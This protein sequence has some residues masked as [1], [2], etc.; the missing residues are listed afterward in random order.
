MESE[1]PL[2]RLSTLNLVITYDIRGSV[3]SE[4]LIHICGYGPTDRAGTRG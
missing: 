3:L 2:R 4:R 1:T